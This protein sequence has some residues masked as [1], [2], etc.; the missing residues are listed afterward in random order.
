MMAAEIETAPTFQVGAPK[1]LF[2]VHGPVEDNLGAIW[3]SVSTTITKKGTE[4]KAPRTDEEW[5]T[6]RHSAIAL[7][8]ASN[9]AVTSRC[10][11]RRM[12][13]ASN[14]SRNRLRH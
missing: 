10:P 14:S 1:V 13:R 6:V 8:E 3:N 2:R 12:S 4:E 11:D 5:G 7:L 9:L